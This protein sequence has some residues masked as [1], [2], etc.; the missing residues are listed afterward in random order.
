MEK[1]IK[2]ELK[3]VPSD[4]D[5]NCPVANTLKILGNKWKARII[6]VLSN[7][8]TL[9]FSEL[10]DGMSDVKEPTLVNNLKELVHL[11]I[12]IR[13]EYNEMPPR[14]EY[15]LSERGKELVP[16]LRQ[17]RAWSH[18]VRVENERELPRCKGCDFQCK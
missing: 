7:M 11:G 17:M 3:N 4:K 14:T 16:I 12:V 1:S 9:R 2:E 13:Y 15:S 6:C 18:G 10:R 5:V 8:G